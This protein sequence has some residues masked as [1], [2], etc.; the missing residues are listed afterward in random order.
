MTPGSNPAH[1]RPRCAA[2][3]EARAND[4][5]CAQSARGVHHKGG[6]KR[7]GLG[8][9]AKRRSARSRRRGYLGDVLP[10]AID[11]PAAGG[12]ERADVSAVE[13]ADAEARY[14]GTWAR[15][16]LRSTLR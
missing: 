16:P 9:R 8:A 3:G 11:A 1:A 2:A 4:A 14:S 15:L 10:G 12:F 7:A 5:L 13:R 6:R